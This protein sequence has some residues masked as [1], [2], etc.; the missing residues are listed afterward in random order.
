MFYDKVSQIIDKKVLLLIASCSAHASD[1]YKT[2]SLVSTRFSVP[3]LQSSKPENKGKDSFFFPL[4][5]EA[6]QLLV[7]GIHAVQI[8]MWPSLLSRFR[9]YGYPVVQIL[10]SSFFAYIIKGACSNFHI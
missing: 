9:R 2:M 1:D 6:E 3:R 7:D 10:A 4:F 8:E 5:S